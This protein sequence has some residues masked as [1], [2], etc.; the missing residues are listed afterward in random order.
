MAPLTADRNTPFIMGDNR[1]GPVAAS[2][3]IYA[4]ALVMRNAAGFL[5]RGA[6]AANLIGVG[7]AQHQVDNSAGSAGDAQL[8]Y[9]PGTFRFANSASSDEITIAEIGKPCFVV[10]DQTVAKTDG[11]GARSPA[12]FVEMV[13][14]HG[15]WVRMDEAATRT[16]ADLSAAIAAI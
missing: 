12:G 3:M 15:V 14:D 10:D 6:A 9:R 4:G 11:S 8:Q 13:D 16:F 7:R 1:E 5:V 2:Q